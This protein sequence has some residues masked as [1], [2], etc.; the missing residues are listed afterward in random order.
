MVE[1]QKKLAI[2][3]KLF[4]WNL[5]YSMGGE[6]TMV[7]WVKASPALG[8]KDH[9]HV[10]EKGAK[11]IGDLFVEKLMASKEYYQRLKNP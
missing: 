7:Q 4:F 8:A 10:S 3:H 6:N 1:T 11:K 2:K 9:I 5:Y